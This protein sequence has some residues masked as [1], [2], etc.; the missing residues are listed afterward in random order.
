MGFDLHDDRGLIF[1]LRLEP[2]GPATSIRL[3]QVD[4]SQPPEHPLWL[5]F[6]F[7]DRRAIEWIRECVWLSQEG[8]ASLL[9]SEHHVR[10]ESLGGSLIGALSDTL[11]DD[12]DAF[13]VF[14]L[15]AD[16]CC[17]M[18]GRRHAT[19]SA[20]LL[21]RELVAGLQADG[22]P[23]LLNGLL[24]RL[25]GIH[26]SQV[27]VHE[28]EIDESEDRVLGGKDCDSG[29]G[30]RRRA[31]ALLRRQMA[32]NRHAL[33]GLVEHLPPW[34]SAWDIKGFAHLTAAL[35]SAIQDL[36]LS[37]ER[38]RLLNEEMDSRLTKRTNHNL[39]FVSVAATIFLPITLISGIFGMNVGGLPWLEDT[40]G[41]T[42]V[43]GCMLVAVLVAF[44]L[45]HW[46]RML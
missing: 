24:Q 11:A 3:D 9:T 23:A 19:L 40:N 35:A 12:P 10:L 44:A 36:E 26:K 2:S 32:A 46:R 30:Q 13:G 22:I 8:R 33:A 39:Y 43:M 5:H 16:P 20:G 31:M 4:S 15:Y 21:R 6:N 14:H 34:W 38:A 1:G 28:N 25:I 27:T 17:L 45:I 37:Q 42:W 41:F 7:V 18:T 29:F